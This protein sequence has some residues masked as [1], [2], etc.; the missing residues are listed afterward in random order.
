MPPSVWSSPSCRWW[1]A[2]SGCTGWSLA[3]LLRSLS[4]FRS[5]P[6]G[7]GC[8]DDGR[9]VRGSLH[10]D[11]RQAQADQLALAIAPFDGCD[12]YKVTARLRI[13]L[14]GGDLK[15][16]YLLNRPADIELAAFRDVVTAVV[17]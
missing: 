12:P 9:A 7:S 6:P 4:A 5:S 8:V 11:P 13:R 15:I 17:N 3:S 2:V 1:P 10:R 16:S 14:R